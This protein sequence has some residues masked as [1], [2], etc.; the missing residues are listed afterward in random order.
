M[1]QR[2]LKRLAL[3]TM[4]LDHIATWLPG[5][6]EWFRYLGRI[7]AP[8]FFFCAVQGYCNTSDRKKYIIRLYVMAIIMR[9]GNTIVGL[10]IDQ[11][12]ENDIFLTIFIGVI[13]VL[14]WERWYWKGILFFVL[15]Q[16]VLTSVL[17][18]LER[19]VVIQEEVLL[20][21]STFAG[22]ALV[23]EGGLVCVILFFLLYLTRNN[24]YKLTITYILFS[25]IVFIGERIF[26][27]TQ[28]LEPLFGFWK[29]EH[30]MIFALPFMLVYNGKKGRGSKYFYYAFYPL[31]LWA[32]ILIAHYSNGW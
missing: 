27:E 12:I 22:C 21:I 30:L 6:P 11:V 28:H 24:K 32:L 5:I 1:T 7:S 15:Y 10:L 8:L 25:L 19:Y 18:M 23:T 26:W 14:C 20:I 4:I 16:I 17:V 31:H 13:V 9:L 2:D 29:I 3:A